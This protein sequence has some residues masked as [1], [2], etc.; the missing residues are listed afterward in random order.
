MKR[1]NGTKQQ[2]KITKAYFIAAEEKEL[3]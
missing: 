2:S 1:P 3:V